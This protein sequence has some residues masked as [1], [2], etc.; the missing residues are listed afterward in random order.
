MDINNTSD[1][2]RGGTYNLKA[3]QRVGFKRKSYISSKR[4]YA[5]VVQ[6]IP[7]SVRL[8]HDLVETTTSLNQNMGLYAKE[9]TYIPTD[10]V[11]QFIK[12]NYISLRYDLHPKVVG[13]AKATDTYATYVGATMWVLQA[14]GDS[15]LPTIS[16]FEGEPYCNMIDSKALNKWKVLHRKSHYVSVAANNASVLNPAHDSNFIKFGFMKPGYIAAQAGSN[17]NGIYIV[18]KYNN[19]D[20]W[21]LNLTARMS[22]SNMS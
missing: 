17:K 19:A 22:Y 21:T 10:R 14:I 16:D 8:H 20:A 9:L 6:R 2:S 12:P 7:Q 18:I 5:P 3:R 4:T 1:Y 11:S 13:R 15:R